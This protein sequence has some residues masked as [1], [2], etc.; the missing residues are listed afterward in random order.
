VND[1]SKPKVYAIGA[2]CIY[3]S[4][5]AEVNHLSFFI[6]KLW[7]KQIFRWSE[8]GDYFRVWEKNLLQGRADTL[9]VF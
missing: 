2:F 6:K 3:H 7:K 5:L 4:S 9:Q 8:L 1:K